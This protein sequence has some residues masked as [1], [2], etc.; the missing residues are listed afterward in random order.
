MSKCLHSLKLTAFAPENLAGT[1]RKGSYS[2]HPFLGAKMLVSGRVQYRICLSL[3][4]GTKIPQHFNTNVSNLAQPPTTDIRFFTE[5]VHPSV[6][7]RN[8]KQILR[9][10]WRLWIFLGAFVLGGM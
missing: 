8:E 4:F 10:F 2:N 7:V 6:G 1:K 5:L 3:L 9:L